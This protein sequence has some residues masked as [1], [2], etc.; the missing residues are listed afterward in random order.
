MNTP[1]ATLNPLLVKSSSEKSNGFYQ[2]VVMQ[3]LE[4]MT[5]GCLHLELPD[6]T[7]RTIGQAGVIF[8]RACMTTRW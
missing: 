4:K 2:R 3:A 7:K 6:G 1:T 5:L 8:S